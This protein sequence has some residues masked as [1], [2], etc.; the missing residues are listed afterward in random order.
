MAGNDDGKQEDVRGVSER[1]D[2][3]GP[4][5]EELE[6]ANATT[7]E[8]SGS[9]KDSSDTNEENYIIHSVPTYRFRLVSLH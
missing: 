5:T 9:E 2:G 8:L 1:K 6:K 7:N 3:S 4:L